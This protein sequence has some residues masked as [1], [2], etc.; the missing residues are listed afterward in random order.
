MSTPTDAPN[1]PKGRLTALTFLAAFAVLVVWFTIQNADQITFQFATW[2]WE[3]SLALL[4]FASLFVGVLMACLA[5]LPTLWS[6]RR[7]RRKLEKRA[8]GLEDELKGVRAERD[9]LRRQAEAL[10]HSPPPAGG[11]A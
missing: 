2:T 6:E 7:Y 9:Q 10:R 1:R 3:V 4:L 8:T 5:V 11:Q